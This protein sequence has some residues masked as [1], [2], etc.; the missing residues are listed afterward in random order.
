MRVRKAIE[1]E[2]NGEHV[3][4]QVEPR[5][6]LV[7]YLRVDRGLTGAHVGCDDGVCGACTV[8]VDGVPVKSCLMLAVQANNTQVTT[9]EGL[10]RPG[11]LSPVQQAFVDAEAVQCGFCTPGFVVAATAFLEREKAVTDEQVRKGMV[12]NLCR[13]GCYQN[14]RKAVCAAGSADRDS[15]P[16]RVAQEEES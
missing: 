9:V 16:S 15:S 12:G 13:C 7:D 3:E 2:I 10:G 6:L 14:I 1:L 11:N 4:G 5:L 8:I